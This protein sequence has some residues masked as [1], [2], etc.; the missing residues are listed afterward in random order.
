[1]QFPGAR[2][3]WLDAMEVRTEHAAPFGRLILRGEVDFY[4]AEAVTRSLR[5]LMDAGLHRIIV[6]LEGVP[7][8]DSAGIGSFVN[9]LHPLQ[10]NGGGIAFL[11]APPSLVR[12]F[13]I[14][15]MKS[16]FHFCEDEQSA[17][18]AF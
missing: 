15:E 17:R 16:A 5:E 2:A 7:Y 12:V 11:K 14:I 6:D 4:N 10:K 18:A 8:M 1:M 3:E 13:E 9:V